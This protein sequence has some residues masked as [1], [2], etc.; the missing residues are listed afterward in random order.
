MVVV[1]FQPPVAP[2]DGDSSDPSKLCTREGFV[3]DPND[4]KVF[5]QCLKLHEDFVAFRFDCPAGLLFDNSTNVCN[6]AYAVQ[7]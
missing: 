5:Y 2:T 3:R 4:W 1:S 6:W 7:N